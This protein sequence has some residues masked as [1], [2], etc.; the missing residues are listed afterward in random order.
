MS[1]ALLA[2]LI[3]CGAGEPAPAAME[4]AKLPALEVE[5]ISAALDDA[6]RRLV[7]RLPPGPQAQALEAALRQLRR[8]LEAAP[9]ELLQA[10][11]RADSALARMP[12][13]APEE[14]DAIRLLL[15]HV[16]ELAT[17]SERAS[18]APLPVPNR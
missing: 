6:D 1:A 13:G 12:S 4:A 8:T 10:T 2:L 14:L 11:A 17:A 15:L 18:S 7:P 5:S 16:R 3:G 9:A